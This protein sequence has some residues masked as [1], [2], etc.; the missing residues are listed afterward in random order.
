METGG[1]E[2]MEFELTKKIVNEKDDEPIDWVKW[3]D[4]VKDNGKYSI[5]VSR[6]SFKEHDQPV[7]FVVNE[8]GADGISV[9]AAHHPNAKFTDATPHGIRLANAIGRAFDL[10]GKVT[11]QD[12]CKLVNDY[13][14]EVTITVEKI[15][16][17]I[18]WSVALA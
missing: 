11:A 9:F 5:V 3:Y 10:D 15:D 12:M 7:W 8:E 1:I 14:K 13:E 18:L 16:K 4:E 6:L 2:Q 17:C